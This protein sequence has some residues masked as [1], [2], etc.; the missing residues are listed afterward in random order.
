MI[1]VYYLYENSN[2][3]FVCLRISKNNIVV[4]VFSGYVFI[5]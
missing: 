4:V 5:M 3:L 1:V 2:G